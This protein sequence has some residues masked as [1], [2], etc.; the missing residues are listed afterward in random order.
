MDLSTSILVL[1]KTKLGETDLIITGL[2]E[3]GLQVRAV[4]KGARR[5]GSK[6]GVHLELFSLSR[7]LIHQGRN[8]GIITEAQT[9][10]ANNACRQ[11]VA[12]SAGA[13][14]VVEL[15]DRCSA[16][17]AQEPRLFPLAMEALRC[18]GEVCEDGIALIAAAGV[19]K[20]AAQLGFYPCLESCVICDCPLCD[21]PQGAGQGAP[22][23]QGSEGAV[24][25]S[26]DQ[27]G[28]VC[29][30][31]AAE[32][33]EQ[34]FPVLDGLVVKWAQVLITS[35]FVDLMA[36][37]DEKHRQLGMILLGF[38]REWVRFHLVRRLKSLDFL[39]SFG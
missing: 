22:Q 35:R 39:M 11:D 28:V 12:H 20:I 9:I 33:V 21:A 23:G 29:A 32:L 25:F 31:C 17:G 14:V 13:S 24:H 16:D 38:A 36:Y 6:L 37:A 10:Q 26:Y 27:G 30:Q 1:K 15:I 4:A 5:P 7:V 18:L 3:E 34:R 8:L 2:S 19:L